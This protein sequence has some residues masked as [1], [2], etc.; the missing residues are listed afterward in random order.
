M[1]QKTPYRKGYIVELRCKELLKEF[2]A[3]HVIRS[4]RS[5]TPADLVAIFPDRGEIWLV[6][7]KAGRE[8]PRD[9]SKLKKEFK[10]LAKL[11]G[12]YQVKTLVFMK[13]E[14]RYCFFEI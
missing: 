7:V 10:E 12:T 4:S 2:G 11:K 6:Q 1:H 5:L 8:A 3:A 14:G 13:K 9:I